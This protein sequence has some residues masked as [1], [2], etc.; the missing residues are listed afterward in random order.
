MGKGR[1]GCG[2]MKATGY[3]P[4]QCMCEHASNSEI[5]ASSFSLLA[6]SSACAQLA[7]CHAGH[8]CHSPM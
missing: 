8:L 3:W 4:V 2:H 6:G 5:T 7:S 1:V